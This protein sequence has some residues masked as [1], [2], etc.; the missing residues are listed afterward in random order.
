MRGSTGFC[1]S[2]CDT[3]ATLV[4]VRSRTARA[5]LDT[6]PGRRERLGRHDHLQR[7]QRR[8]GHRAARGSPV[9][10]GRRAAGARGEAER[11]GRGRRPCCHVPAT[12]HR[13][14]DDERVAAEEIQP[15]G[16]EQEGA[17]VVEGDPCNG[18]SSS[19][20]PATT[21]QRLSSKTHVPTRPPNDVVKHAVRH[22]GG[23]AT[24]RR[25]RGPGSI[26]RATWPS[27]KASKVPR[28]PGSEASR[29]NRPTGATTRTRTRRSSALRPAESEH[30]LQAA[31]TTTR[32]TAIAAAASQ[33]GSHG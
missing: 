16:S 19:V 7:Q 6:P 31:T 5:S 21:P 2:P 14:R 33:S 27:S 20:W 10:I 4:V 17:E 30:R 32:K 12:R 15:V 8:E 28:L 24:G 1:G 26:R 3:R 11:I 13:S 22:A 25:R 18:S 9:A 29:T 23:R